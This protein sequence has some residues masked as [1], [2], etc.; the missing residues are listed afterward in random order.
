QRK[1]MGTLWNVYGF[2]VLYADLDKFNPM[3]Y[4]IP[5]K[6]RTIMDKWIISRLNSLIKE[7]DNNLDHYRIT[8]SAR[9][10]NDF[11][12]V[13]S[14]WY[15]RRSRERFWAQGMEEDKISAYLTLYEVLEAIARL[16]A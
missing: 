13:L 14:N 8:E 3:N 15:V 16:T 12:D 11:V 2:Y 9:V 4:S 7:V 1:F 6:D 10:I 5:V